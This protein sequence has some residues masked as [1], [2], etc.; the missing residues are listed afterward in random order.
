MKHLTPFFLLAMMFL[1][2]S[3][4]TPLVNAAPV[5]ESVGRHVDPDMPPVQGCRQT[6]VEYAYAN[7][8][9]ITAGQVTTLYWGR[10]L[11]ARA[12]YLQFPNGGGGDS[13]PPVR[14]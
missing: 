13:G 3:V 4:S 7:P 5:P 6:T 2:G 10:V 8:P 11:G 12:A 1:L 14:L 9:V